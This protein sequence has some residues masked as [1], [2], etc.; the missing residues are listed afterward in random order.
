MGVDFKTQSLKVIKRILIEKL[1]LLKKN[2]PSIYNNIAKFILELEKK[3]L[4]EDKKLQFRETRENS[5]VLYIQR[6]FKLFDYVYELMI[7]HDLKKNIDLGYLYFLKWN[8]LLYYDLEI[9]VF[10]KIIVRNSANK[11]KY[12]IFEGDKERLE[13]SLNDF[14]KMLSNV[15]IEVLF[16]GFCFWGILNEKLKENNEVLYISL[17]KLPLINLKIFK[18]LADIINMKKYNAERM[19]QNKINGI[20]NKIYDKT[21]KFKIKIEPWLYL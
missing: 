3:T 7:N 20:Y 12:D 10:K 15:E 21:E 2:Q 4:K 14:F 16:L 6:L 9:E 18:I 1:Y 5:D 13:T 17:D 19:D 11:P 8:N